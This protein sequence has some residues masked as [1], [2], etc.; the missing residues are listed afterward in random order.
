[1]TAIE[2]LVRHLVTGT[3]ELGDDPAAAPLD[4]EHGVAVP[5]ETK[6]RGAPTITDG[7]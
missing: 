5:W 2:L 7:P 4:R 6:K 3:L 1:M